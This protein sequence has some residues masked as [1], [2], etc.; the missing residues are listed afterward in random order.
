MQIKRFEARNMTEAL[1][2]VKD[3]LGPEA[4][5]LSACSRRSA[6]G[7]LGCF[8]KNGVEVTAAGG[9]PL[10][11]LQPVT[12]AKDCRGSE[13]ES[14]RYPAAARRFPKPNRFPGSVPSQARMPAK[15]SE[16]EDGNRAADRTADHWL[17]RRLVSRGVEEKYARQMTTDFLKHA[18]GLADNPTVHRSRLAGIIAQMGASVKPLAIERGQKRRIA[19]VGPSGVGKTTAAAK[20]AAL[21]ALEPD[22]EVALLSLDN[23]RVAA[24]D[25]LRVYADIIGIPAAVVSDRAEMD[26]ALEKFCRHDLVLIDTPGINPRDAAPIRMLTG[27]LDKIEGLEV[28]LLLSAAARMCDCVDLFDQL[29]GLPVERL[30]FSKIDETNA[31]GSLLNIVLRLRLPVACL[32]DGATGP[33]GLKDADLET[34]AALVTDANGGGSGAAAAPS[35]S[36]APG[37]REDPPQSAEAHA[38]VANRNSNIFHTAGCKWATTIKDEN[39]IGFKSMK[40]ARDHQYK[41]CRTCCRE[42]LVDRRSEPAF[43]GR[44]LSVGWR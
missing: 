12:D 18:N 36:A 1:K 17:Y 40:E 32:F 43:A 37:D 10:L 31:C 26:E 42:A 4:V 39:M 28:H 21:H 22:L 41:P 24:T 38:Y 6:S 29:T 20:L 44:S 5:I 11:P 34:L 25:Q 33:N 14:L 27:M 2:L 16:A 7:M 3:E 35:A 13:L 8:K 30:M 19:L 15:R 9:G 23:Y